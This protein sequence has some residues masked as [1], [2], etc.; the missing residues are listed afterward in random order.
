MTP[1][2]VVGRSTPSDT[3]LQLAGGSV[4]PRCLHAVANLG[5][6]DALGE[7]P[8]AGT[9]LAAATGAHP[10][11]LDRVLRL[12][13]AYGIFEH[14]DG[15]YSHTPASRLLRTDHP[16]SMRPLVRMLG[17]PAFWAS[18]GE[19]EQTVLTGSPAMDIVLPE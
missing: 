18:I 7:S 8:Q 19:L 12:L 13:S 3:L 17:L 14:R 15:R 9:T 6:A 11:A 10:A 2:A 16:Q 4:L 5:I 1:D